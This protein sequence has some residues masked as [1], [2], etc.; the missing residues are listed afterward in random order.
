MP[1][2]DFMTDVDGTPIRPVNYNPVR[3]PSENNLL[4]LIVVGAIVFFVVK[5]AIK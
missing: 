5:G 4:V 2:T 1:L 3:K